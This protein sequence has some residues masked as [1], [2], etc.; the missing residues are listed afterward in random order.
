MRDKVDAVERRGGRLVLIG[1]GSPEEGD[2]FRSEVSGELELLVDPELNGYRAARLK[3]S[4]LTAVSP[5]TALEFFKAWLAGYR[6]GKI[7]GDA[8]QLGGAFVIAPGDRLLYSF[9]SRTLDDE[10]DF[11]DLLRALDR[12]ARG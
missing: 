12:A 11:E 7:A 9:V 3:R 2:V 4:L 1:N 6:P 5:R 8:A 10:A